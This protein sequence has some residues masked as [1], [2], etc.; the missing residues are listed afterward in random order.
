M[1]E[2]I[3]QTTLGLNLLCVITGFQFVSLLSSELSMLKP[4][5]LHNA[6]LD[7]TKRKSLALVNVSMWNCLN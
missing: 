2:V 5:F 6:P 1:N 4:A 3:I 7:A